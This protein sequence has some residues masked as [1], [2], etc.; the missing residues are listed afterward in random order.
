M[1][2]SHATAK[3]IRHLSHSS[4][5]NASTINNLPL[6]LLSQWERAVLWL[7][8]WSKITF[9]G[10]RRFILSLLPRTVTWDSGAHWRRGGLP[11]DIADALADAIESRAKIGAELASE[12]RQHAAAM[13]ARPPQRYGWARVDESTGRDKRGNWKR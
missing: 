10:K 8:P 1:P 9:P 13:R 7:C 3:R 2:S 6:P 5:N 11:A 12:L 4:V